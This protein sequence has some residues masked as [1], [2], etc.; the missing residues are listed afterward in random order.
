MIIGSTKDKNAVG[1]YI[2]LLDSALNLS[3]C[4]G[5]KPEHEAHFEQL[6]LIIRTLTE[7]R[8]EICDGRVESRIMGI[9][10]FADD[11]SIEDGALAAE[12]WKA[13]QFFIQH[14]FDEGAYRRALAKE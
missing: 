14:F 7:V 12:L 2:H 4:L 9:A 11:W 13:E 3:K 10:R 1:Q 6:A 5:Q 8:S